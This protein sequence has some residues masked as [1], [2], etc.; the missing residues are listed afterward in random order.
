[1]CLFYHW[2]D[3]LNSCLRQD[4]GGFAWIRERILTTSCHSHVT[5]VCLRYFVSPSYFGCYASTSW[6]ALHIHCPI[7][8][9]YNQDCDVC[10]PH[11]VLPRQCPLLCRVVHVTMGFISKCFCC[12]WFSSYSCFCS[13]KGGS[14]SWGCPLLRQPKVY[15]TAHG[16]LWACREKSRAL[17]NAAFTYFHCFFECACFSHVLPSAHTSMQRP[18]WSSSSSLTWEVH[19]PSPLKSV[20]CPLPFHT[21]RQ[22]LCLLCAHSPGT[23]VCPHPRPLISDSAWTH[24]HA[25]LTAESFLSFTQLFPP[26]R[27]KYHHLSILW[28]IWFL[29]ANVFSKKRMDRQWTGPCYVGNGY[30]HKNTSISCL[31]E[32]VLHACFQTY[33]VF[34]CMVPNSSYQF[35]CRSFSQ[36]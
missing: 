7:H 32:V 9:L 20:T 10:H 19:V 5:T 35:N 33:V 24:P 23:T 16:R 13:V 1:M 17:G 3:I 2:W 12:R 8:F 21:S 28:H 31:C 22:D 14:R 4:T 11:L 36:K 18:A 6:E 25:G 27:S 34:L 15:P 30:K 29:S 26:N